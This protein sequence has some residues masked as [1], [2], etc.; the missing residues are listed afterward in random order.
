MTTPD[1]LTSW[2]HKDVTTVTGW[3]WESIDSTW[4]TR[5][6]ATFMTTGDR[7]TVGFK[8]HNMPTDGW[9]APAVHLDQ[10][11]GI[12]SKWH[13]P[14][15]P[16]PMAACAC[17][18][19]VLRFAESAFGYMFPRARLMQPRRHGEPVFRTN[20]AGLVL[21]RVEG[22]AGRSSPPTRPTSGTSNPVPAHPSR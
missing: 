22:A 6:G 4:D 11:A 14:D 21:V 10:V 7:S 12:E 9:S 2:P 1:L 13:H 20:Q 16:A 5:R 3:R 18:Y 19:R 15:I 8:M 17:G